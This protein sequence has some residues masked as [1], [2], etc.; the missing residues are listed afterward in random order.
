MGVADIFARPGC[1]EFFS[2]LALKPATRDLLQHAIDR[3]CRRFD[4]TI[5]DERYKLDWSDRTLNLYDLIAPA[6]A[7][8]WPIATLM[9]ARRRVKRAIKA[10][11]T[12]LERLHV[13]ALGAGLAAGIDVPRGG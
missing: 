4:L 3:G 12:A 9:L 10:G 5:G 8:G 2:D 7:R 11:P 13:V 1:R 6:I